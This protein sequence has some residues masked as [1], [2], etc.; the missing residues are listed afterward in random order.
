MYKMQTEASTL[1]V[2]QLNVNKK[3]DRKS[4]SNSKSSTLESKKLSPC[5][6]T[7]FTS[8]R[9]CLNPLLGLYKNLKYSNLL[10]NTCVI[11]ICIGGPYKSSIKQQSLSDEPKSSNK[12][13]LGQ[14]VMSAK[15]LRFK[16]LQNQLADAHYHLNELANENRLLKALQKKQDSALRRYEGTNAEL[17]RIINSHHE[18]LRVLQTKY[19]KLKELHRDTC[20]LLKEKENELYTIN[21]Q[22]KH[23]LQLSKDRNLGEREKLQLQIS[24]MNHEMRQQQETI[25]IL[26][27]KL[28]LESKSLKHQLHVEISKHKETQKNLQEAIEKLKTLECLLDNKEKRLYYNGQLPVYNKEKNLGS[29]SSTNLSDI[30]PSG[31]NKKSGNDTPKD[32]L[33]LLDTLESNDDEKATEAKNVNRA[34]DRLK[35]ETMASLHQIRKFR[36]QKSPHMRKHAHSMSDLRLRFKDPESETHG[37]NEK[38]T[39][40]QDAS[41]DLKSTP[42]RNSLGND[43]NESGGLRKLFNKMKSRASRNLQREMELESDYLSDDDT[44]DENADERDI[45]YYSVDSAKKSRELYARLINGTDDTS[46][47]LYGTTKR[48]NTHY[49]DDDDDEED[50]EEEERELSTRLA[51]DLVFQKR[52]YKSKSDMLRHRRDEQFHDSDSEADTEG[53][54]DGNEGYSSREYKADLCGEKQFSKPFDNTAHP[55][56]NASEIEETS[57]SRSLELR[58]ISNVTFDVVSA[59]KNVEVS[60]QTSEKTWSRGNNSANNSFTDIRREKY[61]EENGAKYSESKPIRT[62]TS[63]DSIYRDT[64]E[65]KNA[66]KEMK[67]LSSPGRDVQDGSRHEEYKTRMASSTEAEYANTTIPNEDRATFSHPEDDDHSMHNLIKEYKERLRVEEAPRH[68]SDEEETSRENGFNVETMNRLNGSLEAREDVDAL[69]DNVSGQTERAGDMGIAEV[70]DAK[71]TDTKRVMNFNKEKL[72]ASMKAI[73]DNENIEFLNQG[74]KNHNVVSR[75]QITQ[76]LYRGVPTHSRPKRD[77]IKD[78]F[79]DNHIENKVRGTCSKSH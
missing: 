58:K 43:K 47:A 22:N 69:P 78:I 20:N 15:I 29:H 8:N 67:G 30:R 27:R 74:F 59:P 25:Q 48:I 65:E 11:Y 10:H 34:G 50:E 32:N 72:L 5:K 39:M 44:E 38:I 45:E 12:S 18:E 4:K 62:E 7:L 79:E 77:V 46:D 60:A 73:D 55:E 31:R 2:V 57:Q 6:N 36:L 49:S 17:P 68:Y 54:V 23:L 51:K 19:K 52:K 63:R 9:K 56:Y 66:Y 64:F 37:R 70:T 21:S 76:N 41:V 3:S 75:M 26:H 71:Q 13:F 28:A 16:Q 40:Y 61:K 35:S 42:G 33:P 14:R 1:P 24:D 53:K